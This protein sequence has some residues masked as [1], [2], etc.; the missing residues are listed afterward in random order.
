MGREEKEG[1]RDERSRKKGLRRKP[2][3]EQALTR[4]GFRAQG[5]RLLRPRVALAAS[6]LVW[7]EDAVLPGPH[8]DAAETH[9]PWLATAT[10][11]PT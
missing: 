4:G 5:A 8:P 9:I 7:S 2:G 11:D 1:E 10:P 6:C 3:G